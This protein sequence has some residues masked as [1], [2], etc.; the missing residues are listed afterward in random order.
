VQNEAARAAVLA[1][2]AAVDLVV[3]FAEET[4]LTLIEALKPDVL[5]KG[6]DYSEAEVV[7]AKAVK[8]W[9]GRVVLADIVEGYST[10]E[11]I[12]KLNGGG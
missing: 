10:T 7:G 4:P 12:S 11:T 2:F 8:S 1:S 6:A 5:V 9:G 3:I